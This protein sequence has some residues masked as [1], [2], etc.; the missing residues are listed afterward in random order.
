MYKQV[1]RSF[2][3][4]SKQNYYNGTNV[5]ILYIIYSSLLTILHTHKVKRNPYSNLRLIYSFH[6]ENISIFFMSAFSSFYRYYTT[7]GLFLTS[8]RIRSG[9]TQTSFYLTLLVFLSFYR[10]DTVSPPC[11]RSASLQLSFFILVVKH[12]YK[13]FFLKSLSLLNTS[14]CTKYWHPSTVIITEKGTLLNRYYL[15][16]GGGYFTQNSTSY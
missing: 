12:L 3:I 7:T 4:N 8:I 6:G 16:L 9:V 14:L 10:T 5:N 11:G 1:N 15:V 13:I 2:C